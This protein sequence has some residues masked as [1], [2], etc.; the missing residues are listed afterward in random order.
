M[1]DY[2]TDFPELRDELET[3][4]QIIREACS[5]RNPF[6]DDAL[7]AI[8]TP[9]GKLLRPAFLIASGRIAD[10]DEKKL[11]AMAAAVELLHLATLV[12]DDVLDDAKTRRGKPAAH[13]LYGPKRAVLLGD[14]LLS[15]SFNLI[16]EYARPENSRNL[17]QTAMDIL[18]G[19]LT[20]NTGLFVLKR[21]VREYLQRIAGKTAIL[22]SMSCYTGASE[23]GASR[24]HATALRR[25]GYDVGMGF[26]IIDDILD[27][28]SDEAVIGKPVGNDLMHGIYTLPLILAL[29]DGSGRSAVRELER[30]LENPPYEPARIG[31]IIALVRELGG[32]TRARGYAER[33]TDRAFREIA[34]LPECRAKDAL[35]SLAGRLLVREY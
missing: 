21:S 8:V 1:I 32:P 4:R 31:R 29:E 27:Y 30:L 33:Y 6:I 26:Q 10:P 23:S 25:M 2:W 12:H 35:Y 9:G 28:E 7:R 19:E 17:S 20:Q 16:A 24:Q 34:K 18:T 22:F 5:S 15:R 14:Y 11:H 13:A 3:T